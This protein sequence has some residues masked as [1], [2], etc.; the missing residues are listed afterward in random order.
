MKQK[1]FARLESG[2]E[3]MVDLRRDFHMYP[4]LS[5]QEFK[6]ARKIADYQK[7][8]GLEVR[9]NV[10]GNGVIAT[11]RGGKD[12]PTVAVRADFDALPI[13]EENEVLYKSRN[14]GV[15]HACGHDAH[16][17]I[18]LGLAKAF[19][20]VKDQLAGNVVFI[21]QHAE[22]VDPGG[23]RSMIEDG[24]L[25]GVDVIF[26]THMENYLPVDHLLFSEE[27]ILGAADDFTIEIIGTGGH[28]AFPQDTVDVISTGA[29][30]IN[31]LNQITSRKIDPL[32]SVVLTIGV[33]QAGEAENVIPEKAILKGTVRSFDESI[34]QEVYEWICQITEYTCKAFGADH[35]LDYKF[36]YPA[37]KNN[38]EIT[39][40]LV[41][42][43]KDVLPVENIKEMEPNMGAED[44]SYFLQKTPGTYF[45]T[46]SANKEKG[47][48]YPY[49]HP[50]FDIDERAILN[51]AKVIA[52]AIIDYWELYGS[53]EGTV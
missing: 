46:G 41:K 15:M 32:K 52:S 18:A 37:T 34:R 3:E 10:G 12:G 11:L 35:K 19:S 33:F 23:A 36:G 20:E 21:H 4:E 38:P 22:E 16:T 25:N 7:G 44:F 47:F 40:L 2:F 14:P 26:A 24:A 8:L 27:Y 9:T 29:Q 17:A 6:T 42:A 53:K 45:F 49:H 43:A 30:L 5:F 51:G 39:K 31:S 1:I 13:Q 50:R 28:G 48:V